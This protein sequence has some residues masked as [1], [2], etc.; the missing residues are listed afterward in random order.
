LIAFTAFIAIGGLCAAVVVPIIYAV[1]E[2][3][4][5]SITIINLIDFI[6]FYV[7]F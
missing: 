7:F 1:V 5:R 4:S 6:D 2:D 3:S